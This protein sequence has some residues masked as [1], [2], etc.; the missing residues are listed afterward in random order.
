MTT[1]HKPLDTLLERLENLLE[2]HEPLDDT[3]IWTIRLS[4]AKQ[5]YTV[6]KPCLPYGALTNHEK[7]HARDEF[8]RLMFKSLGENCTH[9]VVYGESSKKS[10]ET[11]H[12]HARI[13]H[14]KWGTP[15]NL[16]RWINRW[17][18]S[19][20]GNALFSTKK[21]W[22]NNKLYSHRS[23]SLTYVC[24]EKCRIKI[25]NYPE[26]I[27][28]LAEK[29]GNSWSNPKKSD[30]IYKKV[31]K[32][33]GIHERTHGRGVVRAVLCYYENNKKPPPTFHQ[34]Q[35]ILHHIKYTVDKQY[36]EI[37]NEKSIAWYDHGS[38]DNF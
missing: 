26:D 7:L 1:N 15:A 9:Y 25:H 23:K 29:I 8:I 19:E 16:Y 14:K 4:P 24:K 17:F 11:D 37:F 36:R 27:I 10:K 28:E 35:R 31:I 38:M 33:Y 22:V 18:P 3:N 5:E 21:V 12:Y 2:A 13:V 30:P 34:M 6:P 20:H 32:Q